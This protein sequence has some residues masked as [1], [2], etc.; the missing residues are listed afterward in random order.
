MGRSFSTK[1]LKELIQFHSA[2]M[3]ETAHFTKNSD[4]FVRNAKSLFLDLLHN[5]A[6]DEQL[7]LQY[8]TA[9][10]SDNYLSGFI[11]VLRQL[12]YYFNSVEF[13]SKCNAFSN[14]YFNDIHELIGMLEKCPNTLGWFFISGETKAKYENAY[15]SLNNLKS[16]EFFQQFT[17]LKK[18]EQELFHDVDEKII[19]TEYENNK[20]H[21]YHT[22]VNQISHNVLVNHPFTYLTK[23]I[24]DCES[25]EMRLNTLEKNFNEYINV[26]K[27]DV[28]HCLGER[29]LELLNEIPIE[30]L[31]QNIKRLRVRSLNEAGYNNIASVITGGFYAILSVQGISEDTANQIVKEARKI[32][33]EVSK[34]VKL[35][36]SYDHKTRNTTELISDIYKYKVIKDG[37]AEYKKIYLP[38]KMALD[39]KLRILERYNEQ[40]QWPFLPAASQEKSYNIYVE[41]QDFLYNGKNY[42][43]YNIYNSCNEFLSDS[44]ISNKA[45]EDYKDN[46]IFYTNLIDD[47]CPGVFGEDDSLYELPEE[48]AREI[49][50]QEF[51]PDGL[52]CELRRYQLIG[53]K[54]ILHQERV[55]LGDEMGLG[56]TIEAIATMVSLRNTGETH[57]M[58]I[59]PASVISNWIRE[60]KKKSKLRAIEI[61]GNNKQVALREWVRIGGVAVTNYESINKLSLADGFK[62]GMMVVDEAHYIKNPEASRTKNVIALSRFTPRILMMTGTAIENNVNEMINLIS[63]L[64]VDVAN[65]IEHIAYLNTASEFRKRIASVYYRRKRS[66]V[67]QELPDK[68]ELEEWCRLSPNEEN[69]YEQTVL[70]KSYMKIRRVSWNV[71]DVNDSSK[72]ARLKEL[73]EE[74]KS[75][76]RKIIVF[77]YFL[78]TIKKVQKLLGTAVVGPINGSVSV[79]RRQEII[80]EFDK[81]KAGTVLLSQIM[82][83]GTGLNIQSASVVIF[84]EPQLK[85]SIENQAISRVYRMG[86][87][88]KVL[89]FR[90]LAEN[91]IDE[92]IMKLLNDKQVIFDEFAD[93]SY[94]A[95][96]ERKVSDGISN[97]TFN[98][99]VLEEIERI[100]QK[101]EMQSVS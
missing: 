63:I 80:D 19:I 84:C 33:G 66:D 10:F 58:V 55:L 60:I 3:D 20:E 40:Y 29:T 22:L 101:H 35:R 93:K 49:Q 14:K 64:R 79:L 71:E 70:S 7:K 37:I 34:S 51:F 57:F 53:V 13:N 56:K 24:S 1:D 73:V 17:V 77:S 48:L 76:G 32:G 27:K 26:I 31:A 30:R 90:L 62:F 75:E 47:L 92:R 78:D 72:A 85:P 81:S 41:L 54:Y 74:A 25:I 82:S 11:Q 6:F 9:H 52:L 96:T 45:W 69:I 23:T 8:N 4:E 21:F 88:R 89:I 15:K 5:N 67:L 99:L 18:Q 59:C 61:H 43:L 2:I 50:D 28:E 42:Q 98:Q 86:Q 38:V 39:N 68:E 16:N 94:A 91:T 36:L 83:G 12:Y 97:A 44:E 87:A 46:S 100:K 65:Q 95:E